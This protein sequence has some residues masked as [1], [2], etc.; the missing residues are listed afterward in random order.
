MW[1]GRSMRWTATEETF[2]AMAQCVYVV[3]QKA[4]TAVAAG[5]VVHQ[6]ARMLMADLR[7]RADSMQVEGVRA[8]LTQ[9]SAEMGAA[10]KA[11]GFGRAGLRRVGEGYSSGPGGRAAIHKRVTDA[12]SMV[13][14]ALCGCAV[15]ASA[16]VGI[17]GQSGL[18][19]EGHSRAAAAVRV[20]ERQ[21]AEMGC[22][23]EEATH[24]LQQ[25]TTVAQ[26]PTRQQRGGERKRIRGGRRRQLSTGC[27][28]R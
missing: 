1:A 18:A 22:S 8:G 9:P 4:S 20:V 14:E 6:H 21:A 11:A 2:E 17:R 25:S 15:C 28:A 12:N 7:E 24:G 3:Q 26:P 5:V 27:E 10:Y 16:T 23:G 19:E 13:A